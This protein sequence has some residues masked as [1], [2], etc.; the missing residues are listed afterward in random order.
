MKNQIEENSL[1]CSVP[2]CNTPWS[3]QIG[4]PK[5]SFHQWGVW[6]SQYVQRETTDE[7]RNMANDPK[8]WAKKI[9]RDH[10]RGIQRSAL[11]VKFAKQA[12]RLDV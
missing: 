8:W 10:D 9:L 2:L 7:D 12:L 5:C 6:P 11:Q 3:V 1:S 4:A